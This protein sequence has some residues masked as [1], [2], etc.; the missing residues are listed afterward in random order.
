VSH[1]VLAE[2]A[3]SRHSCLEQVENSH[4]LA[5]KLVGSHLLAE[6]IAS[7]SLEIELRTELVVA[8]NACAAQEQKLVGRSRSALR[9]QERIVRGHLAG[10]DHHRHV[11][12]LRHIPPRNSKD[13]FVGRDSRAHTQVSLECFLAFVAFP[14]E[15]FLVRVLQTQL[16]SIIYTISKSALTW[17]RGSKG[18]VP[19]QAMKGLKRKVLRYFD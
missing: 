18:S 13:L 6:G 19:L 11:P 3:V 1:R 7:I 16:I 10:G 9:V 17:C 8:W 14:Q 15:H 12:A 5:G 4:P 2:K